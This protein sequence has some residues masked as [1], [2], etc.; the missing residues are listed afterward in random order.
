MTPELKNRGIS[1]LKT[2]L[3]G[4]IIILVLSYF[5]IDIKGVVESPEAQDNIEYVT[6]GTKTVWEKYLA[7]PASYLWNTVFVG[8]LWEAFI[9]NLERVRDGEPTEI[10][11]AAPHL[12]D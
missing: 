7:E 9:N 3:W 6:E 11:E 8:L 2:L 5:K 1:I 10:E 4:A 12:P